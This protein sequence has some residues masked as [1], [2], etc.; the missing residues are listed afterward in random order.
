MK[1]ILRKENCLKVIGERLE[2]VQDKSGS[3]W[4]R[5]SVLSLYLA[6]ADNILSA[7]HN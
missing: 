1:V 6:V 4:M 3:K 7:S 5:M 2:N